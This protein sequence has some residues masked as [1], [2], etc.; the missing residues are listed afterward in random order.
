MLA[1]TIVSDDLATPEGLRAFLEAEVDK[2]KGT[3]DAMHVA[4]E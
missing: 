2:W 1:T 4:P 3:L